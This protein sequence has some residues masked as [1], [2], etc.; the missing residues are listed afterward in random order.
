MPSCYSDLVKESGALP[1]GITRF[2]MEVDIAL[3]SPDSAENVVFNL[4]DSVK[5]FFTSCT[6][7]M[8]FGLPPLLPFV[9]RLTSACFTFL[10]LTQILDLS[11]CLK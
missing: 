8:Y 9:H 5:D 11:A 6:I 7:F 3:L 2:A 10:I 4:P 1:P